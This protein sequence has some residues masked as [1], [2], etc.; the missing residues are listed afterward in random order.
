MIN[1]STELN[2]TNEKCNDLV[3]TNEALKC[4]IKQLIHEKGELKNN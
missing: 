4:D 2:E 1:K 3:N